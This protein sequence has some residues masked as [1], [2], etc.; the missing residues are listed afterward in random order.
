[1][2]VNRLRRI[3]ESWQKITNQLEIIFCLVCKILK[4]KSF[5]KIRFKYF[6]LPDGSRKVYRKGWQYSQWSE[7][8]FNSSS[9]PFKRTILESTFWETYSLFCEIKVSVLFWFWYF[10]TISIRGIMV[11]D[12][13]MHEP[14]VR[15]KN[16]F[17]FVPVWT[18]MPVH[19]TE[20]LTPEINLI[21]TKRE[22]MTSYLSELAEM[23]NPIGE[24]VCIICGGN[25]AIQVIFT[26]IQKWFW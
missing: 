11:H 22:F 17:W 19:Q 2:N 12:S 18:T 23:V 25:L 6:D 14:P 9:D 26:K 1:M 15:G 5:G 24:S 4:W 16:V 8:N 3:I 21:K 10:K 20:K 13:W 7:I